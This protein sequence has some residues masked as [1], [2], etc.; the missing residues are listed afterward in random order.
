MNAKNA[1]YL[2]LG[3]F[4]LAVVGNVLK[5]LG[6]QTPQA[7]PQASAPSPSIAPATLPKCPKGT[8]AG[9]W[10]TPTGSYWTGVKLY[11]GSGD[12]K[13]LLATVLGGNRNYKTPTGETVNAVKLQY[14][15]GDLDWK[16]RDAVSQQAF[17]SAEDPAI[18]ARQWVDLNN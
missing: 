14:Q 18:K 17:V 2:V 3:L 7:A 6:I 11:Q 9:R 8:T 1:V 12:C 13:K 16:K 5:N 15:N 10:T 4:V